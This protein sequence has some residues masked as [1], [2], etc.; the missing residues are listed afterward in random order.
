MMKGH[1]IAQAQFAIGR[2]VAAAL[3][4]LLVFYVP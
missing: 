2:S 3:D 4:H 1:H